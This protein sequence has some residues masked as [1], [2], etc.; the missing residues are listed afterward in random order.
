MDE[1]KHDINEINDV[2]KLKEYVID[3]LLIQLE[4]MK[5]LTARM[6]ELFAMLHRV[7]KRVETL[8]T[9]IK[10]INDTPQTII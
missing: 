3:K 8:E 6:E 1:T 4:L 5:N 7:E 2:T 9:K 10:A